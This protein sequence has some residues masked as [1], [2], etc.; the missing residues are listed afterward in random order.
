M[1]EPQINRLLKQAPVLI[2]AEDQ[3]P[4]CQIT[5]GSRNLEEKYTSSFFSPL[6]FVCVQIRSPALTLLRTALSSQHHSPTRN[7]TVLPVSMQDIYSLDIV[8]PCR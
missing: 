1:E 4:T 6:F 3:V 8:S 7:G 2:L 5:H